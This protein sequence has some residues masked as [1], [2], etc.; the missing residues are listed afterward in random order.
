[1][2][3]P[4]VAKWNAAATHAHAVTEYAF[5]QPDSAL[6]QFEDAVQANEVR[7]LKAAGQALVVFE[8]LKAGGELV[9]EHADLEDEAQSVVV[10]AERTD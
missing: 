5:L 6:A 7:D 10:L 9:A 2:A 3:F 8:Y 1:M 4:S